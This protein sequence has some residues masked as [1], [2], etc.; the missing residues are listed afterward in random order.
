M[1]EQ[2][3]GSLNVGFVEELYADFLREPGSVPADWRG[4]FERLAGGPRAG[5]SGGDGFRRRPGFVPRSIFAGDGRPAGAAGSPAGPLPDLVTRQHC[6]D[7]LVRNYRVRGH[8]IARTNPLNLPR[9]TP[10]ELD[11]CECG[12]AD[13]DMDQVFA[14]D[15]AGGIEYWPLRRILEHLR[16]TYCR[17]I[18]VQ[19]MHID[20]LSERRWLL[21]RMEAS[22]NRCQ[23]SRDEQVRIFTRLTDAVV[24]E[25]F[26]QKK[27]VGAKSFS[28]E[29]GE[30]LVPLLD[31]AIEQAAAQGIDTI[32]LG[33]AHR[34]RLNVLANIIGKRPRDIFR[35]FEDVDPELYLYGGDVKY[36][37]G[38]SGDW[39]AADGR[40][41]HLSLCF[42]PSHLEAIDPVAMGRVRAKQDRAGDAER[43][44]K[45]LLVIHGEAAFA[46]E[47][48][49]QET[50]NLS[51]LAGYAVGGAIHVII[52]NQIGFTTPPGEGRSSV[53]AS[54]VAR[55]LQVPIFHVN[56]EDPE[57]V[58]QAIRLAMDFRAEFRRDAVIEM[59]CY[60]RRGHNETDE[61]RFTQPLLYRAIDRRRSVDEAYLERLIE[62]GGL[63]GQDARRIAEE[64]QAHLEADL[65]AAV[66]E[67]YAL[68]EYQA[69]IWGDYLGG[70]DQPGYEVPTGVGVEKL[71]GLLERLTR[72]PEGFRLH[73]T[74]RKGLDARVEMARGERAV[75][76]SAAEALA[77]A[78]LAVQGHRV[79]LSGQDTARGTFSQRHAVLF[80]QQDGRGYMPLA[81][82][83]EGQA[84]VEVHNSPLSEAGVLGFEYG[85]SLDCPEGLVAWEAQF[86]DFCNAAQVIID[87]FIVSA[88]DKWCRLSGLV[89]LLPHGLEGM[90]PEHS[91]ARLERFLQLAADDCIQV[92]CPTT[93]AQYFH[94][95]RRQVLRRWRK[96]LV[97]MTP[98]GLLRHPAAASRLEELAD[99]GFRRVIP[100]ERFAGE[101]GEGEPEKVRRIML[102]SGKIYYELAERRD[103]LKRDDVALVRVEQLYPI[104]YEALAD[105][106]APFA[107]A[108]ALWVQEE[109]A[110]M[111]AWGFVWSHFG[112]RLLGRFGLSVVARAA[113]T[114]PASGAASSYQLSRRRLLERAFDGL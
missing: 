56:G 88:Q 53:Y 112:P 101:G 23:L 69:G 39:T 16:N 97:V 28:L 96:P 70:L 50:L 60:R 58:A 30:T 66:S 13:C 14:F 38:H 26:V 10:P 6:V 9:P 22:E 67:D 29:G 102:C 81:H 114:A 109:P 27:F 21:G 3:P 62:L 104:P 18:G 80:D 24:F 11:P 90:G 76:W 41:V 91:S 55:M 46:G 108:E 68:A 35:E 54:E 37:Q 1:S 52:D 2:D 71:V 25:Q 19:F 85:Y 51:E 65:A 82:L 103:E 84:A 95:L 31:L 94:L 59:V 17:S 32:V 63:T 113:M 61:P 33:M 83:S 34:G 7:Q 100:D 78:T 99:G 105:A 45:M 57:A 79:R 48:I 15:R 47:G 12:L 87:Q 111:G 20:D 107:D 86:G 49:V 40:R 77:L 44:R 98:K 110:N 72:V 93:P 4:Y 64:R 92:A 89:M 43:R 8:I 75:D 5:G 74:I 106:L 73:K 36:H 42:N